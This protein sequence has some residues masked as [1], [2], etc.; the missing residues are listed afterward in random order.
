MWSRESV[1]KYDDDGVTF[2]FSS[3]L[4]LIFDFYR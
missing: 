3:L 1:Y 4:I 2:Q